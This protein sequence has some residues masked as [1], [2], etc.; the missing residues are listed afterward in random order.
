MTT[1]DSSSFGLMCLCA[2]SGALIPVIGYFVITRTRWWRE[3]MR[4]AAQ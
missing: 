1:Y 2:G 4:R 3:T